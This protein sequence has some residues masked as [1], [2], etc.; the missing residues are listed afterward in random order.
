MDFKGIAI[1]HVELFSQIV[2]KP[3][4]NPLKGK[5]KKN[6]NQKT[7]LIKCLLATTEQGK[8]TYS[9]RRVVRS[10]SSTVEEK[11]DGRQLLA[12][13]IAEGIHEFLQ[14]GSALD[15]EE[16]LVVVIGNFDVQVL[17]GGSWSLGVFTP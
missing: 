16:H 13:A 5:K 2:S 8:C 4:L 3:V 1:S 11:A 12:L 7:K 6:R 17:D 9:L 15:F 14:L 10:N